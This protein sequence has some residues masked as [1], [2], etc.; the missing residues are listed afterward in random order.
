MMGFLQ[1]EPRPR[2]GDQ[3][4]GPDQALPHPMPTHTTASVSISHRLLA[5]CRAWS[6]V[7][8]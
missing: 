1:D 3:G 7:L 8:S 4:R 5:Q 6:Q 2:M